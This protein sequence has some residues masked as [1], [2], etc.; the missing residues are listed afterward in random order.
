MRR[1]FYIAVGAALGVAATRRT[2]RAKHQLQAA[3]TPRSV[4]GEIADAIA[5]FGNA[6]GGFAADVRAGMHE[7]EAQFV[8]VVDD[9]S[10][11]VVM[12]PPELAAPDI[13]SLPAGQA[14]TD[15]RRM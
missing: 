5:E 15:R 11:A 6:V 9:F 7:R 14:S 1:S 4:A 3:L 13:R 10:G 8:A 12:S 2:Q